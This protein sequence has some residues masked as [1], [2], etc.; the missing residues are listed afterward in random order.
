[1]SGLHSTPEG[2]AAALGVA[3]RGDGYKAPE[4][5]AVDHTRAAHEMLAEAEKARPEQAALY[6]A[7][8][9]VHATLALVQATQEAAGLR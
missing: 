9:Q 4:P 1:M 8:A 5:A 6:L 7:A 2:R 3:W